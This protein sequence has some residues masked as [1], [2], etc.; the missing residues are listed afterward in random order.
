MSR[1]PIA[2]AAGGAVLVGCS[3]MPDPRDAMPPMMSTS[4]QCDNGSRFW[5]RFDNR[6][7][8]ALMRIEDLELRMEGHR[9]ASG[10]H[11]AGMEHDLRGKGDTVVLTRPTGE[12]LRCTAIR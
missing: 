2:L 4:F 3:Y 11:Y 10:I 6:D 12:S 8:S 7:D 5:V 9:V 1:L